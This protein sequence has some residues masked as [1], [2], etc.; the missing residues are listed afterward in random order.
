MCRL[1]YFDF[2]FLFF[3]L[4]VLQMLPSSDKRKNFDCLISKKTHLPRNSFFVLLL[5]RFFMIILRMCFYMLS[6]TTF[7]VVFKKKTII[8]ISVSSPSLTEG[9]SGKSIPFPTDLEIIVSTNIFYDFIRR[10]TGK[11][12]SIAPVR[13][14]YHG[15]KRSPVPISRAGVSF[16]AR[17]QPITFHHVRGLH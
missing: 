16:L 14:S 5:F 17:S 15:F 2:Q 10:L 12:V 8:F 1:S 9:K 4:R 3:P 7:V 13:F 11:M 6:V